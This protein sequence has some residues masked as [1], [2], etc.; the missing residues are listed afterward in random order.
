VKIIPH[1]GQAGPFLA[2]LSALRERMCGEIEGEIKEKPALN[3]DLLCR[4]LGLKGFV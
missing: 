3:I 1:H 2:R 4:I